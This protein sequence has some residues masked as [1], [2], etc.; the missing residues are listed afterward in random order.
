MIA[1]LSGPNMEPRKVMPNLCRRIKSEIGMYMDKKEQ[2]FR[3]YCRIASDIMNA[4]HCIVPSTT[5]AKCFDVSLYRARKI[6]KE[7]V[8]DGL[9]VADTEGGYSDYSCQIYCIRGYRITQK[10]LFTR[11][12]KEEKWKNSKL[13]A[14]CFG[15][16]AYGYYKC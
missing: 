5:I 7:L 4:G 15:G 12:Y 9:L 3:G 16:T 6:I 8:S 2:I 10:A 11:E 1:N 14:K 13:M